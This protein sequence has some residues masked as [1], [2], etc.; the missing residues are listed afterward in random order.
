[1]LQFS[2][3]F[4]IIEQSKFS[5]IKV[6]GAIDSAPPPIKRSSSRESIQSQK[7]TR[8]SASID[9][10]AEEYGEGELEDEYAPQSP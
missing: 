8:S 1:M 7:S 3:S 6:S 4:T 10:A 5:K 9:W 2:Q